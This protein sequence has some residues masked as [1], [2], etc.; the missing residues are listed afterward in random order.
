MRRVDTLQALIGRATSQVTRRG[1]APAPSDSSD[2]PESLDGLLFLGNPHETVP[3]ALLL[4]E[5]LGAVDILGWQMIRL[6]ANDDK[7][8]DRKSVV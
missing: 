5:R 3:R 7:T 8:T 4:D 2:E 6:L 1:E